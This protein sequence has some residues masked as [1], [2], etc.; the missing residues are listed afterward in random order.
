MLK[1][2]IKKCFNKKKEVSILNPLFIYIIS[3]NDKCCI[4]YQ[5]IYSKEIIFPFSCN[6]YICFNCLYQWYNCNKKIN[7]PLCR[8]K[9][10][11]YLYNKKKFNLK[12]II[13]NNKVISICF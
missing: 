5:S 6:H 7:C 8:S 10:A 2:F 4:C 3:K 13:V 1:N 11:D 12:K 9:V